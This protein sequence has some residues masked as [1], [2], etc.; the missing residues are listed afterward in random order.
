M[1]YLQDISDSGNDV[2]LDLKG[3]RADWSV[4][5][6]CGPPAIKVSLSDVVL[7][8]WKDTCVALLSVGWTEI[9]LGPPW[10]SPLT[11]AGLVIFGGRIW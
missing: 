2:G 6:R 4:L 11:A 5:Y 10:R 8:P 7:E 1:S 3:L 9:F